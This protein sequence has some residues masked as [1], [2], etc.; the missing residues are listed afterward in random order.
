[1]LDSNNQDDKA[2][3]DEAPVEITCSG[4]VSIRMPGIGVT[5]D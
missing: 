4:S 3:D 1:M 2:L 5:R